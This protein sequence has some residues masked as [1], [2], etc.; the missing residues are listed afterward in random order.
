M[1][2]IVCQ[3]IKYY[4]Y[5]NNNEDPVWGAS[6]NN[7]SGAAARLVFPVNTN[8]T[9]GWKTIKHNPAKGFSWG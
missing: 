9:G 1:Y 8:N 5:D 7:F 2:N 4:E 6:S 3:Y